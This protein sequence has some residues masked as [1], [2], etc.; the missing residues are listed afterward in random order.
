MYDLPDIMKITAHLTDAA[1]LAVLGD[2]LERARLE[3]NLTQAQLA[4]EAGIS[5]DTLVRLESGRPVTTPALL[6]VLRALDLLDR[7]DLLAPEVAPGPL[8]LLDRHG[9]QRRRAA[10]A[11]R[12]ETGPA[13]WSW[14]VTDPPADA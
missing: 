13:T 7:L 10:P 1:A 6:R 5:R 8:E 2:R 3:R 9:K 14:S 4:F 12:R 11:R